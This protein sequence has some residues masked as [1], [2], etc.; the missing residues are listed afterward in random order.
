VNKPDSIG[1][2][3][4]WTEI[5]LRDIDNP[6]VPAVMGERGQLAI[7]GPQVMAG[8]WNNPEETKKVI[9][10]GWLMTGDIGY[11]DEDGYLFI[12]DRLKDVIF[13]SGFK[14]YP[15]IIEDALYQHPDVAE[16]V[17]IGIPDDYRGETPKAFVTLKN[18]SA[19]SEAELLKFAAGRLNPIER[20]TEI[21]FRDTLPKTLIGKLSKKELVEE[22]LRTQ[23]NRHHAH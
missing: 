21:E 18:G 23:E 7:K 17:V 10:D 13:C 16:V 14:V 3:L 9:R 22:H 19:I 2:P 4:P 11:I 8:Y 1:L 15:R 20:P 6:D 5:E 12:T